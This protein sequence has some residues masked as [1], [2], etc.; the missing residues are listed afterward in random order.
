MA[1]MFELSQMPA[2]GPV[3]NG[4]GFNVQEFFMH[5]AERSP[6]QDAIAVA[7]SAA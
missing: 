5:L 1:A 6:L 3:V 4:V 2:D 7:V